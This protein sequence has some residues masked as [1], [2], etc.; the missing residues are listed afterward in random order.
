MSKK[1]I[2]FIILLLT[3]QLLYGA[4]QIET[5]FTRGLNYYIQRQYK[6]AALEWK[7]LLDRTPNHERARKYMEKA[8][9]KH[10]TMQISFYKG[11]DFFNKKQYKEAISYYTKTITLNPRHQKALY[12]IEVAWKILENVIN[13]EEA[14]EEAIMDARQFLEEEEFTKAIGLYKIAVLLDP[15]G[16]EAKL[17]LVEAERQD[18]LSNQNLEILL[19]IE[20]A[21]EY[22]DNKQYIQAIQEWSKTLLLDP[23]NEEAREGL[24]TDQALLKQQQLKEKIN[25]IIS[26]GIDLFLNKEYV[27]SKDDFQQVL[28]IEP[29]NA[30][31]DE[32]ITKIDGI[33]NK[34][35][36]ERIQKNEAEKHYM[37]G[38]DFFIRKEYE[39]ALSKFDLTI[40]IIPGHKKAIEYRKKC[41]EILKKLKAEEEAEKNAEVQKLI[42]EGDEL[43]KLG[44]YEN[45]DYNFREVLKI[46]P[47][48]KDAIDYLKLCE[49]ALKLHKESVISEDSPYYPI[50]KNLELKGIESYKKKE[51]A[52]ARRYFEEIKDLFPLNN[53]ANHYI[54]M[55]MAKTEPEKARNILNNHFDKGKKYYN[56]K[57]YTRAFYEFNRIKRVDPNYPDIDKYISLSS[58]PPSTGSDSMRAAF[59]KGLLY[60]SQKKYKEAVK[61]WNK[62]VK[63]D[64]SPFSNPYLARAMANKSKAEFRLRGG[65]KFTDTQISKLSGAK[66]KKINKHYYMGVAYYTGG[67]YQKAL[68]EFM[69]VLKLDPNH[70]QTLKNIEKIKKRLK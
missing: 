16:R 37:L 32:Y 24:K 23:Q 68:Q 36:E 19:H 50:V 31:A 3:A 14:S 35:K 41:L 63:L 17:G 55:I 40:S 49:E 11:L 1:L 27:Q 6:K 64:K 33:L 70:L 45:A 62:V 4:E 25:S 20:A 8:F 26:R 5:I 69:G 30:V 43:F 60:F 13:R 61:E 2:L 66:I 56:S 18:D 53:D 12:Y 38:V 59:N 54:L 51:Y 67:E 57:N 7:K 48:N 22:H 29:G 44:E 47:D 65:S 15:A 9:T 21:R 42:L 39:K 28:I 46:E 58:K 52:I 10:N 34:I